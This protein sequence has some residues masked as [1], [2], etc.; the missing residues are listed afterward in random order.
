MYKYLSHDQIIY[1]VI[2]HYPYNIPEICGDSFEIR[3][4]KI[5][6]NGLFAKKCMQKNTIVTMFPAHFLGKDTG[7]KMRW[8][9]LYLEKPEHHPNNLEEYILSPHEIKYSL[10]GI[11]EVNENPNFR[12]HLINDSFSI[13]SKTPEKNLYKETLRYAL[14]TESGSN[15][16]FIIISGL[17]LVELVRDIDQD[18]EVLATFGIGYWHRFLELTID[19][20]NK[21]NEMAPTILGKTQFDKSIKLFHEIYERYARYFIMASS[22]HPRLS[23]FLSILRKNSEKYYESHDEFEESIKEI[24]KLY[25]EKIIQTDQ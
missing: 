23:Q 19:E 5:H 17:P 3:P 9:S 13:D 6:G 20:I 8:A 1:D 4:S 18:E 21:S 16:R 25:S 22:R 14:K 11:P 7:G 2:L 10:C 15:A 24:G 12:G